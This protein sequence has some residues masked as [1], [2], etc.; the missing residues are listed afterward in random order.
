MK[1][2]IRTYLFIQEKGKAG[3]ED[4]YNR[5]RDPETVR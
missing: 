3:S 1:Y 4:G 5:R 2:F